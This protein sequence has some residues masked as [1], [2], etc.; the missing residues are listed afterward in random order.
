ML[1]WIDLKT[2]GGELNLIYPHFARENTEKDE[3]NKR[4]IMW[5]DVISALHYRILKSLSDKREKKS[6]KL[7]IDRRKRRYFDRKQNENEKTFLY[8]YIKKKKSRKMSL[9][10]AQVMSS[11]E[12]RLTSQTVSQL[13]R[14]ESRLSKL[15][16]IIH[17]IPLPT[18]LA[19]DSSP[20]TLLP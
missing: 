18:S 17:S 20:R 16:K 6:M 13:L 11:V 5:N 3:I 2:N 4:K 10:R 14:K 12:F 9:S 7:N 1:I 8:I 15:P 19:N